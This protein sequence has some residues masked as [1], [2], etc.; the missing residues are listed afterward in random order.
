MSA[1]NNYS[2][3]ES[4]VRELEEHLRDQ[5]FVRGLGRRKTWR[6][7]H[8]PFMGTIIA[9]VPSFTVNATSVILDFPKADRKSS[10]S[11]DCTDAAVSI[12]VKCQN[13]TSIEITH[14]RDDLRLNLF[15]TFCPGLKRLRISDIDLEYEGTLEY[16]LDG[17]PCLEEVEI[18]NFDHY[19]FQNGDSVLPLSSASTLTRLTLLCRWEFYPETM[20]LDVI[21]NFVNLRSLS[22]SPLSPKMAD[23]I[24]RSKI[25]L[26]DFRFLLWDEG[27]TTQGGPDE[28]VEYVISQSEEIL[29]SNSIR[30]LKEFRFGLKPELGDN[31]FSERVHSIVRAVVK[32]QPHIQKLGLTAH[33]DDSLRLLP[34]LENL[35]C[36]KWYISKQFIN[37][38]D[39][40]LLTAD[41]K[42]RL[43]KAFQSSSADPIIEVL[44]YDSV[45]DFAPIIDWGRVD[46]RNE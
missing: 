17:L 24:R 29:A 19:Q 45:H 25:N 39:K 38:R 5:L 13:L 3:W 43:H 21:D 27:D 7:K 35:K 37:A 42:E 40:P 6:F 1:H 32:H 44:S 18:V 2:Q 36:L 22:L 12:L 28:W 26:S 16:N 20:C 23:W 10:F 30:N 34:Q 9:H 41:I 46:G 4:E 31:V 15:S 33:P 8:V 11:K 14:L